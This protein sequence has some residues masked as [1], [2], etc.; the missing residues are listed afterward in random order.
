MSRKTLATITFLGVLALGLSA[1]LLFSVATPTAEGIEVVYT[2][3]VQTL[4][5]QKAISARLT[6][7]A[8]LTQMSYTP[9]PSPTSPPPDATQ[10]T[11]TLIAPPTT[12]APPVPTP[13]PP[14]SSSA[15][16]CNHAEIVKH[17]TISDGV[18][19]TPGADFTKIWRIKNIG[20][21][22]WDE[23]YSLVF[24]N[25]DWM[26]ASDTYPIKKKIHPGDTVEVAVDLVAPTSQGT[27]ISY[28]KLSDA[29]DR[30]FGI[31]INAEKPLS[32]EVTVKPPNNNYA[33]DFAINMCIASWSTDVQSLPCPGNSNSEIGSIT[34]VNKPKLET[35]KQE[36]E[37][38]IWTRP[39]PVK[40]G[41]IKGIYPPYK[42][43]NNDHFQADVGCLEGYSGCKVTFILDYQVPG[44]KV[45]HLGGWYEVYDGHL[46]RINV[47]LSFLV[48]KSVHIILKVT[49]DGK[50]AQGNAFW[51][52]PSIRQGTPTAA[53]TRT[54]TVTSTPTTAVPPATFTPT[55]TLTVTPTA[56]QT[57]TE[58][59]TPTL[60]PTL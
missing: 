6:S 53:P 33:Y 28:W 44:N 11:S 10:P 8:V 30:Q 46:T 45:Q 37:P 3:A 25:G 16:I 47:D 58:T 55:P 56:T 52:V 51:L 39:E 15:G 20:A 2:R 22:T 27:Y 23:K 4:D 42:V 43:K 5:A 38:A 57:Q 31:G 41:W 17:L 49:N 9:T 14:T 24:V 29:S 12:V 50:P 36:N 60:T 54:P 48:G 34:L 7:I 18:T 26:G 1:C 40:N 59:P 19:L 32:V 35:G 13:I 21:C